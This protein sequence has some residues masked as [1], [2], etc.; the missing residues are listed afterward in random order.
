MALAP[1]RRKKAPPLCKTVVIV[2]DDEAKAYGG[3]HALEGHE[4]RG[5]VILNEFAIAAKN[6]DGSASTAKI[7]HYR[8]LTRTISA[9]IIGGLFGLPGLQT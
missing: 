7:G 4:E 3:S 8:R 6:P 1:G 2:F 9:S 5:D